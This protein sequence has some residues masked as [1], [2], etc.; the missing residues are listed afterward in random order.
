[1]NTFQIGES[2]AVGA[3]KSASSP[4]HEWVI[5]IHKPAT[6]GRPQELVV[7]DLSREQDVREILGWLDSEGWIVLK[8]VGDVEHE[9]DVS[10]DKVRLARLFPLKKR[11]KTTKA[12]TRAV[13]Q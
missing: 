8:N 12:C 7:K 9:W 2:S 4:E 6:D 11:A 1:M 5:K 13:C 10:R 3:T